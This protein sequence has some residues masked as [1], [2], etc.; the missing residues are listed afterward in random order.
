MEALA[1]LASARERLKQRQAQAAF[2]AKKSLG[3]NFLVNDSVIRKIFKEVETAHID[4]IVE[5]GPGLGAL[6]DG[7]RLLSSNLKLIELDSRFAHYWRE[8]NISVTEA[9]ALRWDWSQIETEY[10]LVSN[11]PYQIAASIVVERSIDQLPTC[12]K[13]VLMFQKEVAQRIRAQ[14]KASEYGFLSVLAQT[15]WKMRT[16]CDAGPGDFDPPPKVASRVLSFE[17]VQ[18][19]LAGTPKEYLRFLK[20]AFLQPRKMLASNW[21]Q[22]LGVSKEASQSL[23][24]GQGISIKTRAHE[25]DVATYQRL[26]TDFLKVKNQ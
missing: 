13:M 18:V 17:R 1:Q 10:L 7:L 24:E 9:D 23:L 20:A 8:Q 6:T 3:Q 22:G 26:F 21:V 4:Q 2:A 11:L 14:Y 5:I 16:V 12:K 19:E 25:L 15:F